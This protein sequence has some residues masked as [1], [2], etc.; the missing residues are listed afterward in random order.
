MK[1]MH[2]QAEMLTASLNHYDLFLDESLL[3]PLQEYETAPNDELKDK[4]H[5]AMQKN[6]R[7]VHELQSACQLFFSDLPHGGEA[8][9]IGVAIIKHQQKIDEKLQTIDQLEKKL[10]LQ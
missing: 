6:A 2:Q 5:R 7:M 9:I 8:G 3:G 10:G 1:N 4:I